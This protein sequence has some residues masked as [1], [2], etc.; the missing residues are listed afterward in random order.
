MLQTRPVQHSSNTAT[1]DI[2]SGLDDSI[3]LMLMS[4]A[5][6]MSRDISAHGSTSGNQ[7]VSVIAVYAKSTTYTAA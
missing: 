2:D 6:T 1:N 5:V 4:H 3:T 7:F